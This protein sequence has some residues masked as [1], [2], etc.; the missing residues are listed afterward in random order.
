MSNLL[1]AT[2]TRAGV[3]PLASPTE[4]SFPVD[5]IKIAESGQSS[6]IT[7]KGKKYLV[8]ETVAALVAASGGTL[9]QFTVTGKGGRSF[10]P[11]Q[12]AFP[13]ES[14]SVEAISDEL[15]ATLSFEG[16]TYTATGHGGAAFT[17]TAAQLRDKLAGEVFATG[18]PNGISAQSA[19]YVLWHRGGSLLAP[20]NTIQAFRYAVARGAK[21]LEMD[22]RLMADGSFGCCHDTTIDY[23]TTA[24]G[25]VANQSAIRWQSLTVD[26]SQWLGPDWPN[27]SGLTLFEDVLREFGNKVILLPEIAHT[28]TE[29]GVLMA[30]LLKKYNIST[31]MV[32]VECGS[33][34]PLVPVREAGYQTLL[35]GAGLVADTVGAQGH[36]WVGIPYTESAGQ[37]AAL[38]ATGAKVLMYTVNRQKDYNAAIAKGADGVISDDPLYVSNTHPRKT[39]DPYLMQSRWDGMGIYPNHSAANKLISTGIF[40]TAGAWEINNAAASV[41]NSTLQGWGCPI[42]NDMNATSYR[43]DFT[44]DLISALDT[45]RWFGVHLTTDDEAYTD[46]YS[47]TANGY[48]ILIRKSGQLQV[49]RI[50]AGTPTLLSSFSGTARADG[51]SVPYRVTVS[52]TQITVART[53]N[54]DT[55]TV[56]DSTHRGLPYFRFGSA[57]VAGRYKSV[58][59]TVI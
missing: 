35:Y 4:M 1:T 37:V 42:N 14:C 21:F 12:M 5:G 8:S 2:V 45:G 26:C 33:N 53:N 24:T 54:A 49:Y 56:T 22:V 3:A 38:K 59:V 19:P 47:N 31:D 17:G 29:R 16:E 57:G 20:E 36:Q 18:Y 15:V 28:A 58:S 43:I 50:T 9:V 10:S 7:F 52:P 44:T 11:L 32:I 55:L 34:D 13:I 48:Q 6:E 51:D 40:T 46:G 27:L 41:H 25:N 30:A 23:M 39:A